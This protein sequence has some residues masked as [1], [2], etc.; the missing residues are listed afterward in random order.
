MGARFL[1]AILETKIATWKNNNNN[2]ILKKCME[3]FLCER[4]F[5][6]KI[7]CY[8]MNIIHWYQSIEYHINDIHWLISIECVS[9]FVSCLFT[10]NFLPALSYKEK[11][12]ATFSGCYELKLSMPF[13]IEYK[14]YHLFYVSISY[15][16]V[17]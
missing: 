3:F 5:L 13:V 6:L 17:I 8:H 10:F 2:N 7:E 14:F 12:T 4:F 11:A 16:L 9:Y 15:H 1:A